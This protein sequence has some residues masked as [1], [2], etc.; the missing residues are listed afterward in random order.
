[1]R[2]ALVTDTQADSKDAGVCRQNGTHQEQRTDGNNMRDIA[3]QAYRID[4]PIQRAEIKPHTGNPAQ[5]E[6]TA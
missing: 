3:V 2:P 6:S 1:M 4:D 5:A